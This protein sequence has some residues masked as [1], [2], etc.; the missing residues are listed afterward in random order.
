MFLTHMITEVAA[1]LRSEYWG[2][3]DQPNRLTS[4]PPTFS[5]SFMTHSVSIITHAVFYQFTL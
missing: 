1:V 3:Q 5:A 4:G 2:A